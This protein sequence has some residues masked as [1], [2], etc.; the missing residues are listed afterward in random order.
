[1]KRFIITAAVALGLLASV[2][3]PAQANGGFG[4]GVGLGLGFS[5]SGIHSNKGGQG[6]PCCG[7]GQGYG[8]APYFPMGYPYYPYFPM[9]YGAPAYYPPQAHHGH[10]NLAAPEEKPAPKS[11]PEKKE[12]KL[13]EGKPLP[14]GD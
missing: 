3:A 11:T 7:H 4:F 14:K 5:F 12:G 8:Q 6:G 13:V 10:A 1:M 9:Q 2:H